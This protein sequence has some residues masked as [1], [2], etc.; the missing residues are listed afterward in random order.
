MAKD[1]TPKNMDDDV[2]LEPRR[3]LRKRKDVCFEEISNIHE[4]PN[5]G[6][7]RQSGDCGPDE[8]GNGG[9]DDV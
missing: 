3:K 6:A 9:P 8:V 2:D 1:K 4:V 5:F 7:E